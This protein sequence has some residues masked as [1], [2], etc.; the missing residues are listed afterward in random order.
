MVGMP[1]HTQEEVPPMNLSFSELTRITSTA[2]WPPCFWRTGI[3]ARGVVIRDLS[4][5]VQ[6]PQMIHHP[7]PPRT[8]KAVAVDTDGSGCK[9]TQANRAAIGVHYLHNPQDDLS[10]PLLGR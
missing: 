4:P 5:L 6:I 10:L 2:A 1:Q 8:N 9:V 7:G 3:V